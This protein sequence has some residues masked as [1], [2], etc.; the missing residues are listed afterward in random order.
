MISDV[1]LCAYPSY[2]G[3]ALFDEK[4]IKNIIVLCLRGLLEG[5]FS[6]ITTL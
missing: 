5:G 3:Q 2:V 4:K 1:Y 6:R